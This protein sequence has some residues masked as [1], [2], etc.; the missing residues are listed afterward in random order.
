MIERF[1]RPKSVYTQSYKTLGNATNWNMYYIYRTIIIHNDWNHAADGSR[2]VQKCAWYIRYG[3]NSKTCVNDVNTCSRTRC[4]LCPYYCLSSDFATAHLQFWWMIIRDREPCSEFAIH[5][6][7]C[8]YQN[9]IDNVQSKYTTVGAYRRQWRASSAVQ[10]LST[11]R[12]LGH[13][14]YVCTI[15]R[16]GIVNIA[17]LYSCVLC[18]YVEYPKKLTSIASITARRIVQR[19]NNMV[20]AYYWAR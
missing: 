12:I 4:M 17:T 5:H 8:T 11:L 7:Y 1:C 9:E 14:M 3:Y 2:Y 15:I 19:D 10:V 13:Y 16:T 6:I 18:K 20:G